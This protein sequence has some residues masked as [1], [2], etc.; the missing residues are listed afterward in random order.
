MW[1]KICTFRRRSRRCFAA[2]LADPDRERGGHGVREADE[3]QGDHVTRRRP[4]R[5]G[6]LPGRQH[7]PLHRPAR[8]G[9]PERRRLAHLVRPD[10]VVPVWKIV[11][12]VKD[13]SQPSCVVSLQGDEGCWTLW[14][15]DFDLA[16]SAIP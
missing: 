8:R 2:P 10:N 12:S 5:V 13:T 6:V 15:V 11:S 16:C 7:R 3:P 4:H 14:F 1:I 9:S